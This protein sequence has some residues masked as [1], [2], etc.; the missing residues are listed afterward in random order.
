M[1]RSLPGLRP[2]AWIVCT[3]LIALFAATSASGEPARKSQSSKHAKDIVFEQKFELGRG[4]DLLLDVVDMDVTLETRDNGGAT[5]VVF[6]SGGDRADTREYFDRMRFEARLEGGR[7]EISSREPEHHGWK[8][9]FGTRH[10][11]AWVVISLPTETNIDISTEDGDIRIDKV[12]GNASLN[13]EDGDIEIAEIAGASIEIRTA[14]GDVEAESL[15]G[16]EIFVQTEDGDIEIDNLIASRAGIRTDDGDIILS[17]VE[18]GVTNVKTED[19]DIAIA[20]SG[21]RIEI[22]C[23]DGDVDVALLDAMEAEIDVDDGDVSLTLPKGTGFDLDLG[24]GDVTI[25]AKLDI[26]GRVS[27]RALRGSINDG[28]PLVNVSGND[29]SIVVRE[30]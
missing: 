16:G 22:S 8:T 14:D 25:R 15:R 21:D 9:W 23:M 5:V 13:S 10:P 4:A 18:S 6:V 3:A 7:L 1:R 12:V 30:K 11:R 20:V 27:E 26:D 29:G 17:R 2:S 19:G 28:G 24:G